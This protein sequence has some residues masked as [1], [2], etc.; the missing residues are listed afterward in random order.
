VAS[1]PSGSARRWNAVGA[2]SSGK[3]T[4]VPSTVHEDAGPQLPALERGRVAE[5]R[6]LVAGT[7]SEVA[8]GAGLETGSRRFLEVVDVDPP[9]GHARR[10]RSVSPSRATDPP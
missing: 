10:I 6:V 5:Q 3:A 1:S 4:S 7:P 2:T 9:V 8:E